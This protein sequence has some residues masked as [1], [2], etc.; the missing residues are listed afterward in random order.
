MLGG[1]LGWLT[2]AVLSAI[3]GLALGALVAIALHLVQKMRGNPAH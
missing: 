1:V 3:F 2:Y